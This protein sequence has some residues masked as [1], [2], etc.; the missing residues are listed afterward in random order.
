MSIER[1]L[2]IIK[3]DAVLRG[4]IGKIEE[5]FES[6]GLKIIAMKMITL[7]R[8]QA[9]IFYMVH[10]DKS[11]YNSLIDY[12]ISGPIVVQI[13]QGEDAILKNRNIMGATDPKHAVSGTIRANFALSVE[14][15]SVHG[16]DS[17]ETAENEIRF[18]FQSTEIY[19]Y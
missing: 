16:S 11:F 7:S 19:K 18:F 5:Y 9:E 15:N 6:N 4:I 13:L 3:P 17:A 8:K 2:S 12:M 1:T 10:S 14:K